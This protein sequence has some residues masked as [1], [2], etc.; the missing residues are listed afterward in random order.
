MNVNGT[1]IYFRGK[2]LLRAALDDL[3]NKGLKNATEVILTGCSGM[4]AFA[5]MFIYY[6]HAFSLL[7]PFLLR[8]PTSPAGGLATYLH[9]DYV[10]SY[11][12][13]QTAPLKAIADAG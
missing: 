7:P 11:L 6:F 10:R 1:T 3:S 9:A 8:A 4:C 13:P 12:S 5:C 2:R